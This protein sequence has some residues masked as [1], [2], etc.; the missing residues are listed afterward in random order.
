MKKLARLGKLASRDV[1]NCGIISYGQDRLPGEL[2]ELSLH[3]WRPA[4][5]GKLANLASSRIASHKINPNCE[6]R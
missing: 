5:V 1:S 2:F 4:L 6:L 3:R